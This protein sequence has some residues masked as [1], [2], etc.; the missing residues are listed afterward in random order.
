M[1]AISFEFLVNGQKLEPVNWEGLEEYFSFGQNSNQPIIEAE[2]FTFTGEGVKLIWDHYNAGKI[3]VPLS[4]EGYYKQP[5][6]EG[7][8]LKDYIIDLT[9]PPIFN[10]LL[11]D[12]T[13]DPESV[14][15]QIRLRDDVERLE[16][17][18]NGLTFGYLESV[19]A[20]TSGNYTNVKTLVQPLYNNVEIALNIL[21]LASLE[22]QIEDF[23]EDVGV[24]A[25]DVT[26]RFTNNPASIQGGVKIVSAAVY[27][28]I[29]GAIRVVFAA[30]LLAITIKT[31]LDLIAALI[32]IPLNNKGL[33]LRDGLD[34]IFGHLGYDYECNFEEIEYETILPSKP[35]SN[36][37]GVIKG[38][39]SEFV[40]ITKGYPS[41]SDY[42]YNCGEF[43]QFIK[44]RFNCRID[45]VDGV[46]LF[47]HEDDQSLFKTSKFSEP[48]DLNYESGRPN[49]DE[50]PQTRLIQFELDPNDGY[51]YENP[52]GT[53]YE[54][55][56]IS[57]TGNLPFKGIDLINIPY[58]LGTPKTKL[59]NLE[60]FVLEVAKVA[61]K[62]TELFGG[63]GKSAQKI[64]QNRVNLLKVTTNDF[65]K[66]KL[67]PL[68]G[69]QLTS[70]NR[71]L[72]SAK[73]IEN[74][75]Y[76]NRSLVRGNP[77][78]FIYS[79]TDTPFNMGNRNTI[80]Q[81]GNFVNS[82]GE[83]STFRSLIY[84]FAYDRADIELETR[85]DYINPDTFDEVI[86]EK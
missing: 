75:Y 81:N 25:A 78:R 10:G 22:Q 3:L 1:G 46:V 70:Q 33:K 27:T 7:Y 63:K 67:L 74:K 72:L 41:S 14:E 13:K 64:K 58:C 79:V 32:G 16:Q 50:I 59:N 37:T 40:P 48:L 26:E 18:I 12:G 84:K 55:K 15:V 71:T 66:A 61:D 47:R 65:S 77:Q 11:F 68:L 53:L 9:T 39:F 76:Y 69:G 80:I 8:I 51:T 30:A 17:Q 29:T 31:I 23:I 54:V 44:D 6:G 20:I 52:N 21:A 19:G 34:V 62:L 24:Y 56:N 28:V 35:F 5:S 49:I 60:K 85:R 43:I 42:G 86:I 57:K 4:I 45:V 83:E 38:K 36:E 73:A 82:L 2:K